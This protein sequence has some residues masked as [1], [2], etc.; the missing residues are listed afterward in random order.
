MIFYSSLCI[1]STEAVQFG[2]DQVVQCL[3]RHGA[4]WCEDG[5][6]DLLCSAIGMVCSYMNSY[7]AS[8]LFRSRHRR[9]L[10]E[11]AVS[12]LPLPNRIP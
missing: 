12:R 3:L 11:A 1:P 4:G 7:L 2:H 9:R 6:G 10:K 8:G 5:V